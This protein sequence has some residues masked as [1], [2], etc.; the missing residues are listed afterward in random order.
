VNIGKSHRKWEEVR[1]TD[2]ETHTGSRKAGLTVGRVFFFFL[3][4]VKKE[5]WPFF[6][7]CWLRREVS[8][9]VS[10]PL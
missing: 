10:L 5:N 4:T 6:L 9:V 8:W 2:R 3:K 1:R 7:R